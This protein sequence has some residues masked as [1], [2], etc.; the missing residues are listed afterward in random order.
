MS[1]N[2]LRTGLADD[3]TQ[4]FSFENEISVQKYLCVVIFHTTNTYMTIIC[5]ESDSTFPPFKRK[6]I[7]LEGSK[8]TKK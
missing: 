4:E 3:K 1:G 7:M 8:R 5:P 2:G 6:H